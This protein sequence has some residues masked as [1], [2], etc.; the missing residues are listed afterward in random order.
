[1]HEW[2]GGGTA[3]SGWILTATTLVLAQVQYP[4]SKM[5]GTKSDFFFILEYLHIH[6]EISWGGDPSLNTKFISVSHTLYIYSLKVILY[7]TFFDGTG[8]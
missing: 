4:L 5:P 8:V 7:N 6:N 1:M 2:M 3:M